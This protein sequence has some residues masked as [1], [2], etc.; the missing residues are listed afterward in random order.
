MLSCFALE[1]SAFA[2]MGVPLPVG[3]WHTLGSFIK[4]H[5]PQHRSNL[6]KAELVL[7][8][9]KN[10]LPMFEKVC[11]ASFI[12]TWHKVIWEEEIL[13]EEMQP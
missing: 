4:G 5:F 12:S 10:L 7:A 3:S 9:V 11:W 13:I 2:L 6:G 1:L 8:I